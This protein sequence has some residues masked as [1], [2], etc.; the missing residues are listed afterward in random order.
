MH[1]GKLLE[2]AFAHQAHATALDQEAAELRELVQTLTCELGSAEEQVQKLGVHQQLFGGD[3]GTS[4]EVEHLKAEI[5]RAEELRLDAEKKNCQQRNAQM[6]EVNVLSASLM[7]AEARTEQFETEQCSEIKQRNAAKLNWQHEVFRLRDQLANARS[8]WRSANPR[9]MMRYDKEISRLGLNASALLENTKKIDLVFTLLEVCRLL[10][11]GDLT[12]IV[13]KV[14]LMCENNAMLPRLKNFVQSVNKA[15][16]DLESEADEAHSSSLHASPVWM[17]HSNAYICCV[18][19]SDSAALKI[20]PTLIS[21]L[22]E[23]LRRT[24]SHKKVTMTPLA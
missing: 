16:Q 24:C 5:V 19:M 15:L 10:Q 20:P 1:Q 11:V 7:Q 17:M 12:Q 3:N 9:A 4:G 21:T 6:E 2:T 22:Q 14:S 23:L 8:L 18:T 13:P